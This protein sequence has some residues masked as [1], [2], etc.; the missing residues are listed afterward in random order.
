MA[1][2]TWQSTF[3]LI[4]LA[5]YMTLMTGEVPERRVLTAAREGSGPHPVELPT[6]TKKAKKRTTKR[7]K[8]KAAA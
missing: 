1:T 8:A 3:D 6:T 2:P 7:R 4:G 5:A